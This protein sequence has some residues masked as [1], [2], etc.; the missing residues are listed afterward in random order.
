MTFEVEKP[1]IMNLDGIEC[2]EK[3]GVVYLKLETVA[4]GLGFVKTE[5]KNPEKSAIIV[6]R[7][8][9]KETNLLFLIDYSRV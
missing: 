6:S 4:R 7:Q 5:I 8:L 1:K 9:Y 3:D 2:Y